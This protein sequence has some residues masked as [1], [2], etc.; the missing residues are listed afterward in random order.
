MKQTDYY[1]TKEESVC[2]STVFQ[3]IH[4]KI[5]HQNIK[6]QNLFLKIAIPKCKMTIDFKTSKLPKRT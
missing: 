6:L 1:I 4:G 5:S 2:L 3:N